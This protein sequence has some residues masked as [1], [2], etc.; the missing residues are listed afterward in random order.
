[1]TIR[2]W[3]AGDSPPDG[4]VVVTAADISPGDELL[5]PVTGAR[6]VFVATPTSTGGEYVEVEATYPPGSAK[7]PAHHHPSQTEHFTVLAGAVTV[8]RGDETQVAGTGESFSV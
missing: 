6:T 3:A 5:N 4:G 7:P 8:T 2:R 1:M